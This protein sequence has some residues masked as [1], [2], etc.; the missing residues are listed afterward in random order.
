MVK[1]IHLTNTFHFA[2][3]IHD[4]SLPDEAK[5]MFLVSNYFELY[6]VPEACC[7]RPTQSLQAFVPTQ[8]KHSQLQ[9]ITNHGPQVLR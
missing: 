6:R 9:S 3:R 2:I 1:P 7:C 8:L 4:V 5:T